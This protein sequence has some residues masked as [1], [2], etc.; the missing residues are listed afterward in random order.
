MAVQ[1]PA[2]E[3]KPD[4]EPMDVRHLALAARANAGL[5]EADAHLTTTRGVDEHGAHDDAPMI[6]LTGDDPFLPGRAQDRVKQEMANG[7]DGSND[8][9]NTMPLL[10]H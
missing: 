2:V 6:D 8:E 3:L 7:V 4:K 9:D 1:G 5:G 10:R